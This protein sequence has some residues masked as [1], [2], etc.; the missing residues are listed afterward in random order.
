VAV[1]VAD[2]TDEWPLRILHV[3]RIQAET[4]G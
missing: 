1:G 2:D 3:D 4:D